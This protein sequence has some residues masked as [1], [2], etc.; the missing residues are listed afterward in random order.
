MNLSEGGR[1]AN[2]VQAGA[3]Q[4]AL[5][6]DRALEP[7]NRGQGQ[8]GVQNLCR[9]AGIRSR[10]GVML[11]RGSARRRCR[12]G[13]RS[14]WNHRLRGRRMA[15]LNCNGTYLLCRVRVKATLAQRS[16]SWRARAGVVSCCRRGAEPGVHRQHRLPQLQ[17]SLPGRPLGQRM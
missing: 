10:Q 5:G 13:R 8:V 6:E 9:E 2:E 12:D 11:G 1:I 4:A 14:T 15:P 3:W 7:S 17:R 16:H